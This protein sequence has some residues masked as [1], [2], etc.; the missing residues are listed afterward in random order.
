MSFSYWQKYHCMWYFWKKKHFVERATLNELAVHWY[1]LQS[2]STSMSSLY[3]KPCRADICKLRKVFI[4]SS[5]S[6]SRLFLLFC[7]RY[8]WFQN[9]RAV[10]L[11]VYT[12]WKN[13]QPEHITV[14][15][16]DRDLL[17]TV[18]IDMFIYTV[19]LGK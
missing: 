17:L 1:L 10:T 5:Y 12:R 16:A 7:C 8:D 18:V 4:L 13:I 6:C 2:S 15:K 11:S 3:V 14:D 19:H 9:S